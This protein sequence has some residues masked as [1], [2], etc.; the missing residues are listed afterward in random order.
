MIVVGTHKLEITEL[1]P[2]RLVKADGNLMD[3]SLIHIF[4]CQQLPGSCNRGRRRSGSSFR[5][6]ERADGER[7]R[8]RLHLCLCR[9]NAEPRARH[10]PGGKYGDGSG[11]AEAGRSYGA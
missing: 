3:L 2:L 5:G 4:Y 10:L 8:R 6:A 9:Q 7:N 11:G 1:N